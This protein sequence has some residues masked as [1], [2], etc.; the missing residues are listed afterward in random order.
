MTTY[1]MMWRQIMAEDGA[2]LD[3]LL[4]NRAFLL[5][6]FAQSTTGREGEE[7]AEPQVQ[8]I[9][10]V[11]AHLVAA[12]R[13]TH[14]LVVTAASL[15]EAFMRAIIGREADFL[16]LLHRRFA[17]HRC[18]AA[19][20]DTSQTLEICVDLVRAAVQRQD[21][22]ILVFLPGFEEIHI[23]RQRLKKMQRSADPPVELLS[24][25]SDLLGEQEDEQDHSYL[26][27]G[28]LV[29]LSSVIA[30][31][32]VTLPDMKYVFIHPHCRVSILH[33]SGSWCWRKSRC[34]RNCWRTWR[35]ALAAPRTG[36]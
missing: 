29:A 15:Q 21:G 10:H 32:G 28:T 3:V 8:E 5:D 14:R 35:G 17:L 33:Q 27:N 6:E 25:H 22:N 18:V 2:G 31:R 20:R 4:S 34:K 24:L 16:S 36:S 9:G 26:G 11:L 30:A 12:R 13:C 23:V 7:A 1:G 19:P